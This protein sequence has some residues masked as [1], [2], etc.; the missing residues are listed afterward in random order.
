MDLYQVLIILITGKRGIGVKTAFGACN[1]KKGDRDDTADRLSHSS[2]IPNGRY[3][4]E[5]RVI[6]KF[7]LSSE[8]NHDPAEVVLVLLS[9]AL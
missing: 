5:K 9:F 4:R 6:K 2:M 1:K 8:Y 7:L 3:E